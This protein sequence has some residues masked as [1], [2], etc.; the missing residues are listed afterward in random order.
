MAYFKIITDTASDITKEQAEQMD[1]IMI[2]LS[3]KFGNDEMAMDTEDDFRRFFERL[4][5]ERALPTT[6]QPSP[7]LYLEEYEKSKAKEEDVLVLALSGG[8]SVPGDGQIFCS[9]LTLRRIVRLC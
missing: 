5:T 4:E 3:I 2:P 8:L 7:S 1:V 6:S 9:G